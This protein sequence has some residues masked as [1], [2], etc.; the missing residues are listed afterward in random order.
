MPRVQSSTYSAAQVVKVSSV[1]PKLG[2]G[3]LGRKES[4][5]TSVGSSDQYLVFVVIGRCAPSS[6]HNIGYHLLSSRCALDG[7]ELL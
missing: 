5:L 1:F 3:Q 6:P 2:N 7:L 4:W